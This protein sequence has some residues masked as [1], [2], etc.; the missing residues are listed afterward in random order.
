MHRI[1]H[2]LFAILLICPLVP[3]RAEAYPDSYRT[4]EGA[5]E[6]L[7][8]AEQVVGIVAGA[9]G[10]GLELAADRTSGYIILAAQTAES[11]FNRGLPSWNGTA[12]DGASGFKIFMRFPYG[13]GWSPWL[14]AGFWK[15]DIWTDYGA[16]SY[17]GGW[18]DI[19]YVKLYDF[20][21]A[22][23]FKVELKRSNLTVPSPT[24]GKLSFY[25][26]DQR[27]EAELD[28][29]G[30][31][32]DKPPAIFI[33]T[34]FLYQY[35]LDPDIGGSICSPTTV[36]MI[37]KSYA[38]TVDPVDFARDTRDPESGL[39]GV[40]PRVVQNASEFRLNGAVTR[41]R[42]WSEAYAVL[43]QGGR[44]GMSVGQPLYSGHLM[45][46]AGFTAAGDPIVHDPARSSGY[47]LVYNK[48]ELS[49]SWFDKGGIGYTFYLQD[50]AQAG[51]DDYDFS[52][53]RPPDQLVLLSNYPNPFNSATTVSVR[54]ME[55]ARIAIVIYD[56]RGCRVRSLYRGIL[57]PGERS[58]VWDGTNDR[59]INQ[60]SGVYWAVAQTASGARALLR[61]S[62]LK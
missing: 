59:G 23:Q 1:G 17:S 40:W 16:T 39:F 62:L 19:D 57:P 45:M 22:W 12:G 13:L 20:E 8:E 7:A 34:D 14:T 25:T 42:T 32:A 58:F 38:I 49:H 11:P 55:S 60:S 21:T 44:I 6:L 36:S 53:A 5:A 30:I 9:D 2:G 27:T 37:L 24:I 26:S 51:L 35:A 56:L 47:G 41:Y 15:D 29:V 31:L 48:S 4:V 61:M 46:L 54:V 18:I 28:Y 10:T 52:G 43:E 33:P 3:V 50:P